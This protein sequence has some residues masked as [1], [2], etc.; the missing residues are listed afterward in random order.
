MNSILTSIPTERGFR[1]LIDAAASLATTFD[2][3]LDAVAIGYETTSI[4]LAVEGG[5]AVA[6]IYEIERERAQ[7][8]AEG[9]LSIVVAEAQRR[10]FQCKCIPMTATPFEAAS[11]I[12]A[13]ARLYDL[14]IVLQPEVEVESYDNTLPQE[15]LFEAGG[16]V[17]FVPYTFR[18]PLKMSN[19]GIA[20]DG[21]RLAA[22]A[23]RDAMPFLKNA[24][25]ITLIT[26]N[27]TTHPE[28][29]AQALQ[30]RLIHQ[31]LRVTV[32]RSFAAPADIQ[33]MLL[34]IAADTGLDLIVM[35]GYGHSRLKERILG[36]VTRGM[37]E[38]MTVPTL[39]SH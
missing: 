26:V 12:G 4:G 20:W 16:P 31:G 3:R 25:N 24:E 33:P 29:S 10:S 11:T 5:T 13:L 14:T 39:M 22:R 19:I 2:T 27:D 6:A 28:T 9:A 8:R 21:S 1:G 34:S 18:G 23:V 7:A 30:A 15:I 36:G 38:S 17:L 37:L 32:S 35:G